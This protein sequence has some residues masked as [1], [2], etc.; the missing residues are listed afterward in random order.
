MYNKAHI[1]RVHLMALMSLCGSF[2][3][4]PPQSA[5][6]TRF[7]CR[8]IFIFPGTIAKNTICIVFEVLNDTLDGSKQINLNG[9]G[10]E[11]NGNNKL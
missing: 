10:K 4:R 8:R 9:L 6:S 11:K 7:S 5:Q 1:A 3:C 2:L